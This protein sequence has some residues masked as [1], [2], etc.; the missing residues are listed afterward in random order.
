MGTLVVKIN[1][2]FML[3]TQILLWYLEVDMVYLVSEENLAGGVS[4]PLSRN[5]SPLS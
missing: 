3:Q 1:R 5:L 4:A 2:D